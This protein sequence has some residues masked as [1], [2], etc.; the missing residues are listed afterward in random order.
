MDDWI[1]LQRQ[2][3][4]HMYLMLN[5]VFSFSQIGQTFSF[6]W[7]VALDLALI[8]A[9]LLFLFCLI[10]LSDFQHI[11]GGYIV[12]TK[13]FSYKAQPNLNKSGY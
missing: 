6:F 4:E 11:F 8:K 2:R 3:T 10:W 13:R 1:V 12:L 9:M 5:V 7:Y